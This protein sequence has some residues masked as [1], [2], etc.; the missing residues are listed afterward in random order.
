MT[1][2]FFLILLFFPCLV[3]AANKDQE[4]TLKAKLKQ[5]VVLRQA[6]INAPN[7][8][9]RTE[10]NKQFLLFLR[11]ALADPNSFETP[12]DT[13]PQLADLRSADE[14]FRMINWNLPF[15]DQTNKYFC[16]IQHYDKKTKTYLVH[17]L[18][19]G[20]RSLEGSERKTFSTDDWYGALYYK[21][22]TSRSTRSR[23]RTY[24]LLGWDGRN[25]YSTMK[26]IDVLTITNKTIRFGA[27]IFEWPDEKNVKR[28]I[29]EYKS[30]ASVSLKYDAKRKM[31]VFNQ[32]VPMQ[33]DLEGMREFYIPLLDFDALEWKKRKWRYVSN[34]DVRMS[35][36]KKVYTDPP[37][38]QKMRK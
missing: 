35:D 28:V 29:F 25:Q 16:F 7:D 9:E 11:D 24:M 15:D 23:K 14:F 18:K 1:K 20:Y 17:E 31:I 19:Q 38:P 27:D 30:D 4:V 32:L 37:L 2:R 12:F 5:L 26:V 21:I 36:D 10:A 33:P 8:K 22:I 13:I 3:F 6:T 34:V